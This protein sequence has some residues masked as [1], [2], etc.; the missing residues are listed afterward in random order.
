MAFQSVEPCSFDTQLGLSDI[1]MI[2]SRQITDRGG[3]IFCMQL[4]TTG[5]PDVGTFGNAR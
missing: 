3:S 4:A 2:P 1:L 5:L